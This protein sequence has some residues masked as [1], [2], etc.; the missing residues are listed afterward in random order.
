MTITP[1]EQSR[2]RE[3]DRRDRHLDRLRAVLGVMAVVLLGVLTWSVFSSKD[4]ADQAVTQTLT[5]AQQVTA[6]CDAGGAAEREL[7]SIGACTQAEAAAQGVA[8]GQP[9]P[10]VQA[11]SDEQVRDAVARYLDAHPPADGHTPSEADV[12]AAV[13]RYCQANACRGEDGVDGVDGQDGAD[14]TDD[15]VAAE[16][17]TYCAANNDCRPTQDEINEGVRLY[18]SSQ[19]SPCV[20]PQGPE[21]QPGPVL[22]EYY[23]TRPNALGTGT[24]TLHCS[25]RPPGDAAAPPHYDCEEVPE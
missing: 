15:Q 2:R 16:V 25:L 19:P 23:T 21:G 18:C 7:D 4:A 3:S 20:G 5:L 22:P 10:V 6:A 9:A 13:V 11:A 24:V 12:D 8:S 1:T 17:A 14:V